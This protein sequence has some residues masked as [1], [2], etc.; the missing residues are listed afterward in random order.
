MS[1]AVC[2]IGLYCAFVDFIEF[3][4]FLTKRFDTLFYLIDG[5]GTKNSDSPNLIKYSLSTIESTGELLT[6]YLNSLLRRIKEDCAS[7]NTSPSVI[8][9]DRHALKM[10]VFL[11]TFFLRNT[12]VKRIS[13]IKEE[14]TE[15]A[16]QSKKGKRSI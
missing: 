11:T 8:A 15:D 2:L 7:S 9:D 4:W 12:C 3:I 13:V 5:F 6:T 10:I 16:P 1:F 14:N